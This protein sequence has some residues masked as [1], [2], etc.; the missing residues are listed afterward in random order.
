MEKLK[1]EQSKRVKELDRQ[2]E[3]ERQTREVI[4]KKW[5]NMQADDEEEEWEHYDED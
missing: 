2:L 1:E 4:E 5:S 3:E